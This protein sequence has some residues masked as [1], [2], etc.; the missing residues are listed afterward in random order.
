[1]V[2]EWAGRQHWECRHSWILPLSIELY[3]S[4]ERHFALPFTTHSVTFICFFVYVTWYYHWEDRHFA[5]VCDIF[6][7]VH[8]YFPHGFL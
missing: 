4:L 3:Q 6:L 8:C 1:M 7:I 5:Q 2:G